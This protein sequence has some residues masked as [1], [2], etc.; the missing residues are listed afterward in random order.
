MLIDC[1]QCAVRG[2]AC[3]DCVVTFLTAGM[4]LDAPALPDGAAPSD[5]LPPDLDA[6]ERGA[7]DVLARSGL[8]PPLRL[9]PRR[10]AG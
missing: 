8:V 7:I 6:A 3:A 2:D 1:G 5:A 10:R 4:P 9:E